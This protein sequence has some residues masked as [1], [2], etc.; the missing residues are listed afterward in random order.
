MNLTKS[1]KKTL[2][3]ALETAIQDRDELKNC[4]GHMTNEEGNKVRKDCDQMIA[5]FQ[6]LILKIQS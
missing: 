2:L 3:Y 1:E 6:A 4:Y 5:K